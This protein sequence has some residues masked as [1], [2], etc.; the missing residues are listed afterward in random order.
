MEIEI[1]NTEVSNVSFWIYF[2]RILRADSSDKILSCWF[3][4][5]VA[6]SYGLRASAT[7]VV[8]LVFVGA[9]SQAMRLSGP[10]YIWAT[11]T[12][13]MT[14]GCVVSEGENI[15]ISLF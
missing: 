12:R 14:R 8:H 13:D 4:T 6:D 10:T 9:S 7:V 11:A 5:L 3:R 1:I 15:I 2:Y